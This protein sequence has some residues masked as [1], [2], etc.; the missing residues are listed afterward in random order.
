M[1]D[2]ADRPAKQPGWLGWALTLPFKVAAVLAV[3]ILTSIGIEWVGIY[4]GWWAEPGARHA[5]GNL[6]AALGWIDTQFTRSLLVS[7]PVVIAKTVI[8]GAYHG[9]FVATGISGW[10]ASAAAGSGAWATIATYG[11]A[12]VDVTLIVLV[13]V[14]IL[15]LTSPLFVMAAAVA[16]VDGLVRRDLRRFGAGRESAFVYHYAKRLT[17]PVFITGWLVYLSIPFSIPPNAFLLPCAALFGVLISITVGAFK[18]YL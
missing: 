17:G 14:I 18:K 2:Q 4:L 9:A 15:I 11:H 12:A 6:D 10:L 16:V 8:G 5:A 3:S 1:A 13:R 7:N